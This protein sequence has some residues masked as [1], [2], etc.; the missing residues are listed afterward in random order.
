MKKEMP[1]VPKKPE[2]GR[3]KQLRLGIE[4][5]GTQVE[6]DSTLAEGEPIMNSDEKKPAIPK[7]IT[8][9][10]SEKERNRRRK[11]KDGSMRQIKKMLQ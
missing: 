2:R 11:T 7:I 1:I 6:I 10:E 8:T 5:P 3:E 4:V 9:Q